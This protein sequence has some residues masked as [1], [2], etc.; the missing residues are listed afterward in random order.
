MVLSSIGYSLAA[1]FGWGISDYAAARLSSKMG[2]FRTAFLTTAISCVFIPVLCVP[3]FG[4]IVQFPEASLAAVGLGFV[5]IV[6]VLSSYKSFEIGKLSIVS[7]IQSSF[8]AL[9]TA[10][11]IIFLDETLTALRTLGILVILGGIVIVTM[12]ANGDK[13]P[14]TRENLEANQRQGIGYALITFASYGFML[15]ALKFVVSYLGPLIPVLILQLVMAS[16]LAIIFVTLKPKSKANTRNSGTLGPI[17]VVAIFNILAGLAYNF[18]I[19]GGQVAV[20]ST[21]A[22]LYSVVIVLLARAYLK[23]RMTIRQGVCVT[24]IVLGVA[25]LGFTG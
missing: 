2:Y 8:P 15:F 14:E 18:G 21:I 22:G 13:L 23:K 20:V 7:P 4:L 24:A 11:A 9:S 16:I 6:A 10:L 3:Y 25:I 12:Q 1:A 17:L 5:S 19:I